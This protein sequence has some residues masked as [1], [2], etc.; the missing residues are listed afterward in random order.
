VLSLMQ[1][2][3][4]ICYNMEL[5]SKF[6]KLWIP[7]MLLFWLKKVTRRRLLLGETKM[8]ISCGEKSCE[9]WRSGKEHTVHPGHNQYHTGHRWEDYFDS[10]SLSQD[11]GCDNEV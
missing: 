7:Y 1:A 3:T 4:V 9:D 10:M 2:V 11:V 6:L 8:H 5:R